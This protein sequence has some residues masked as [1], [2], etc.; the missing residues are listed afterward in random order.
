MSAAF[1]PPRVSLA[2]MAGVTDLAFRLICLEKGCE[3]V[4]TEM[5]SAKGL[6]LSPANA[7]NRCLLATD[8]RERGRVS[9]QIFGHEPDVVRR[10]AESLTAPGDWASLDLNMGCPMPK[11][12]NHGDG[13]A[14]MRDPRLAGRVIRAAAEG[15]R[16]PVGV[17]MRLGFAEDPE[18]YLTIGRVAEEAGAAWLTLHART[19]EQLY[20]GWAD[21]SAIRKLKRAVGIPVIGNGD[22]RTGGDALRM[23][24]ETG[25]D[26]VAVGRGAQG[27]PWLFSEIAARLSGRAYSAPDAAEK[28]DAV[29]RHLALLCSLK[30][31]RTAVREMRRHAAAYIQGMPGAARARADL[32]RI[33]T[34]DGMREAL[35]AFMTGNDNGRT[36]TP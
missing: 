3:G 31:E 28:L 16:V 8:A 32:N 13:S 36:E 27:N 1:A 18:A 2:P 15:S 30:G 26:G 22:V 12:V 6:L 21:W 9:A 4:T 24:E 19:K 25:C 7:A 20:S 17:K 5:V 11:I 34:A 35:T 29:L 33:V 14:L 10:I 23:M